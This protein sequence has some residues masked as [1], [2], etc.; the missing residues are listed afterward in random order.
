MGITSTSYI[1]HV[2]AT[3]CIP[4]LIE[5]PQH[6]VAVALLS[7]SSSSSSSSSFCSLT[8]TTIRGN[9][10]S[11]H[12]LPDLPYL[13]LYLTLV[14]VPYCS[15]SCTV[16][17]CIHLRTYAYNRLQHYQGSVPRATTRT[18]LQPAFHTHYETILLHLI[19]RKAQTQGRRAGSCPVN[20]HG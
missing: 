5:T 19:E 9:V 13:Y 12:R 7:P 4:D 8:Y 11:H 20:T 17:T 3:L 1:I 16:H 10:T 2:T 14:H 6:A 18:P 15:R